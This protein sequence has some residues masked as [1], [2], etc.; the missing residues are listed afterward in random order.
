MEKRKN[1][2]LGKEDEGKLST[3]VVTFYSPGETKAGGR[4]SV[5]RGRCSGFEVTLR[6]PGPGGGGSGKESRSALPS[7]LNKDQ[8]G[9]L[10]F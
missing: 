9:P 3:K 8:R 10:S 4:V 7:R 2:D 5:G 6:H 1:W